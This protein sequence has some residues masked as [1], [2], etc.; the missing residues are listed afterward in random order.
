MLLKRS[1]NRQPLFLKLKAKYAFFLLEFKT[2]IIVGSE[3]SKVW[4]EVNSTL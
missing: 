2:T 1:K 3:D 4:I